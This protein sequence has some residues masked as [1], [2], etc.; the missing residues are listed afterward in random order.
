M[1]AGG[2]RRQCSRAVLIALASVLLVLA[3]S[4]SAEGT[5]PPIPVAAFFSNPML[6]SPRL[7]PDG[8]Y[9]AVLYSQGDDQA[10]F[11]R[12]AAGSELTPVA[13][14]VDPETRLNW[15]SWA[16]PDRLLL[17]GT[18]RGPGVARG[19]VTR[20]FGVDRTGGPLSWL[21]KSWPKR[22]GGWEVQFQDQ[23]IH[24]LWS[25]PEH[26]L[27][28]YRDPYK[29]TPSVKAM[30]VYSG[31]IRSRQKSVRKIDEWHADPA[32]PEGGIRAGEGWDGT[33]HRLF[34]RVSAE[35][36]LVE[37]YRAEDVFE[38]DFGFAGFHED[39]TKLYLSANHEGR[40]AIYE[41]D[42][43]SK[44]L[45]DVVFSHPEVD[46]ASLHYSEVRR[47][48][49]GVSYIVDEPRS[50][51]F[52][53]EARSEHAAID[54]ALASDLGRA[55]TN[56]IVSATEEGSLVI[57]RASNETQPPV[58][59]AYDRA[60]HAM[61]FLLAERPD[62]PVEQLAPIRRVDYAARDGLPIVAYLTIPLGVEPRGLPVIVL[63]HGGPWARDW[64][65]Y[66]PEVQLFA[67]RGFAVFQMNFRGSTGYGG[68]FERRGYREWGQAIQD[69]ITDGVKWLIAQGVADPDRIGIYG[70]S[71]GGYS[72]MMGLIRT[73]ELYRAGASY[74]GVMDIETLI[75]DDD[76]YDWGIDWHKP[77][78]GG[79]WGDRTRL[80]DHSPVRR[81]AEIRVPVLLGHGADDQRVHVKHSR[82]M[83][84]ALRDAG[85]QVE[86]L[87]F[88]DEIHGFL[89][90]ANRIQFY[91]RL[92][93]F[94]EAE[95]SPR[96]EAGASGGDAAAT[97]AMGDPEAAPEP[98][99]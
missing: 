96:A 91:E 81:A 48:V 84:S 35:D 34:A 40:S 87:E 90:E 54:Q 19:R 2:R 76:R 56:E 72:A 77:M 75:S 36:K 25:D 31:G 80:R 1:A 65:R 11:V 47:K 49:V 94:F 12:L 24:D 46:A 3:G 92:L 63:P 64:K 60:K 89:L 51:W 13:T 50:V 17:S 42:I 33:R 78:V 7:S 10:V 9:I 82:N 22:G 16:N 21:G 79:G 18:A 39:P 99:L 58:Y 8:K 32:D 74:A 55:S 4:A 53:E 6:S 57:I 23:I 20:L 98:S 69:D 15:L 68:E 86:Y 66:D 71:Y 93:A 95:L 43:P 28:Q 73:P 27:I 30:S 59:Y 61:N 70:G 38:S 83:A 44:K 52:D 37:V 41:F 85:K 14:L 45:L 62:I 88:E 26:V 29:D 97:D 5:V 67:N